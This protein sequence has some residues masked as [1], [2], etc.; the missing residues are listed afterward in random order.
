MSNENFEEMY[1]SLKRLH[2]STNEAVISLQ[3]ELGKAKD[4]IILLTAKLINCQKALDINKEIMRGALTDQ[5][6]IKDDYSKE[7]SELKIKIKQLEE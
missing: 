4:E 6:K 5:N 3:K 2:D 7:I 1:K